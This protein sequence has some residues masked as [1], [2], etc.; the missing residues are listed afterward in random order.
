M[1]LTNTKACILRNSN[2]TKFENEQNYSGGFEDRT[3][4]T[5]GRTEKAVTGRHLYWMVMAQ[6]EC[7]S[8][9]S[10]VEAPSQSQYGDTIVTKSELV[11]LTA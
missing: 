2:N 7:V 5:L 10:H 9:D 8:P 1:K 11:L 6:T 3:V 4:V